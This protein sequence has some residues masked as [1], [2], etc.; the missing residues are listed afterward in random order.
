[1]STSVY[2][3]R[4]PII[5]AAGATVWVVYA[6]TPTEGKPDPAPAITGFPPGWRPTE[7]P[8]QCLADSASVGQ[9][10]LTYVPRSQ[11]RHYEAITESDALI[12]SPDL[13]R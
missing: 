9:Y 7:N 1:V 12:P 8:G 13:L 6:V 4:R 5:V 2:F 10:F 11:F 3:D